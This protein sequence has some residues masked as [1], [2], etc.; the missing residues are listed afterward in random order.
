MCI[1]WKNTTYC[2]RT[3]SVQESWCS[4]TRYTRFW[5][6]PIIRQRTHLHLDKTRQ[7]GLRWK[8]HL[9]LL[10]DW[11]PWLLTFFFS[12]SSLKKCRGE[13][14]IKF[15]YLSSKVIAL[16]RIC[17]HQYFLVLATS[18]NVWLSVTLAYV[19]SPSKRDQKCD[20]VESRSK[21]AG[22]MG[23]DSVTITADYPY[24]QRNWWWSTLFGKWWGELNPY[25][26]C[27][28]TKGVCIRC[29]TLQLQ[30]TC[31]GVYVA[32]S[33]FLSLS[34]WILLIAMHKNWFDL[35][36]IKIKILRISQYARLMHS[37]ST[38][39]LGE[40]G[41]QIFSNWILSD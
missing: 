40:V 38:I 23:H 39:W 2:I 24:Y 8:L 13:E 31:V 29:Y 6:R 1:K 4:R 35:N 37:K 36:R 18:I 19:Q 9:P 3:V 20:V 17:N 30:N 32:A 27:W 10:L 14:W 26:G 15:D 34:S 33:T 41:Q 25:Y 11:E 28:D 5:T 22:W 16:K 12:F 21:W 7:I